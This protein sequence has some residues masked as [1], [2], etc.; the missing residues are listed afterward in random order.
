MDTVQ[1]SVRKGYNNTNLMLKRNVPVGV[2]LK[3]VCDYFGVNQD[4]HVLA[5]GNNVIDHTLPAGTYE[6]ADLRLAEI[7][8]SI[9]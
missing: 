2:I 3:H 7:K 9:E 4:D 5:I 1:L 8:K 6:N